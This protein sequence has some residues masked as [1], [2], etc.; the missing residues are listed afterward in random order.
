MHD[1]VL[2]EVFEG[3]CDLL[4]NLL[5]FHLIKT[6][7]LLNKL[8]EV[9]AR[10]V[11]KKEVIIVFSMVNSMKSDNILV[12]K[13]LVYFKFFLNTLVHLAVHFVK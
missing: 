13:G 4:D 10:T 5:G 7:L 6:L 11:L 12:N 9:S 1:H 3:P 2:V 8:A